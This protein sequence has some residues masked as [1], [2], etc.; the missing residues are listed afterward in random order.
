MLTLSH[1]FLGCGLLQVSNVWATK[2]GLLLERKNTATDTQLN[3]PGYR[4]PLHTRI[5]VHP[6]A[7]SSNTH[8]GSEYVQALL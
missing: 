2:F 1:L 6:Q 8:K 7:L 5:P 4:L 3:P